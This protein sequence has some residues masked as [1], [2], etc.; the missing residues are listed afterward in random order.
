MNGAEILVD[1]LTGYGVRHV[2][3]VPGDTNVAFYAA[4]RHR[5]RE[6]SHILC[7]DERSAA[8]MADAYARVSNRPA[9]V[10][11]PSGAGPMYSLPP[12]AES[13]VS[14]VP[15]LLLTFD[16]PLALERRGVIS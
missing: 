14:G 2:F 10:E 3:G 7:R 11:A 1:M 16:M 8:F 13:N 4:L 6:I 9:V 12:L 5:E 15:V